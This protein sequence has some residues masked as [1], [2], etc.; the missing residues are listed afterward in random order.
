MHFVKAKGILSAKGAMNEY[1]G[2]NIYR[3]CTHGCIYCDS[4]SACYQFTHPFE[5]IEVKE[6]APELLEDALRRKRKKCMIGTGAMCD[7]YLHCEQELELTRRCLEIIGRY[8]FGVAVQTK[9]CRVL[10][11][12]DILKKINEKSKAVVQMSLTTYD[13]EKCRILEPNVST[14][15]ERFEALMQFKENGIPIV[16]WI[17][18]I[19]PYINDTEEN[20]RGL[21]DYCVK[22]GVRGIINYGMGLTLRQG[23]REYFYSCLDRHFP[24]IKEKYIRRYGNDYELPSENSERLYRIMYDE[25]IKNGIIIGNDKV[26]SYLSEFPQRSEQLSIF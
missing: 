9:S 10:R 23:S 4:R 20:I 13:E 16:V 2:M 1:C 14:T 8:G 6:N 17:C 15:R 18:P 5:D 7:P 11:D 24:G 12:M 25:C 26:F 22:A 19:V 3:G 21:M